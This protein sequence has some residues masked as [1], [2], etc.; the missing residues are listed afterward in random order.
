M[1]KRILVKIQTKIYK[2]MNFQRMTVKQKKII[3]KKNKL[4]QEINL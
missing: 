3:I 1:I 2:I 4:F